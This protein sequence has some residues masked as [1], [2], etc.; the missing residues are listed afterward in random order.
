MANR[1]EGTQPGVGMLPDVPSICRL[2]AHPHLN[3]T[4]ACLL[5][6]TYRSFFLSA[7]P[8]VHTSPPHSSWIPTPETHLFSSGPASMNQSFL[9][10]SSN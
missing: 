2:I 10:M 9:C 7:T 4:L 3:T 5:P 1:E 6:V 8:L